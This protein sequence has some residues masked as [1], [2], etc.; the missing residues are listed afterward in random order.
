MTGK[1][2]ASTNSFA[3]AWF[4]ACVMSPEWPTLSSL[5]KGKAFGEKLNKLLKVTKFRVFLS[6]PNAGN[7]NGKYRGRSMSDKQ[8]V[9]TLL[10]ANRRAYSCAK[11]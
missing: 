3:A 4:L 2:L 10:I 6:S 8:V 5:W 11:L 9:Y 1:A 7:M